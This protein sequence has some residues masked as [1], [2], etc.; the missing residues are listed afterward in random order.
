MLN[1]LLRWSQQVTAVPKLLGSLMPTCCA[2]CGQ[3]G[4]EVICDG[5]VISYFSHGVARCRQCAI[6]LPAIESQ[7]APLC[8]ACLKQ[9]RSFDASVV[10]IDYAAPADQLVLALKFGAQLPLAPVFARMLRDAMV[11]RHAMDSKKLVCLGEGIDKNL[12]DALPEILTAVP[13]GPERLAKRGFNQ[14]LEIAKPL[15]RLLNIHLAHTI[16][17]RR[18]D[19]LPQAKLHPDQR[20]KNLRDA[21]I[22]PLQ[23]MALI[24]GR[25]IGVIDDVM[26]TGETLNE[27]ARTLK[28]C[29]A[30]RV[31]NLVFA[32]TLLK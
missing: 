31:T 5:C 14:A 22:V 16:V 18:L 29:G 4:R 1:A 12:A 9:T 21:F 19:T 26:T 13:L 28:R 32:R 6:P 2:L 15:S 24:K 17:E 25:H 23:A 8:G 10:A 27:L 20:R 3:I 11:R 7:S 30:V